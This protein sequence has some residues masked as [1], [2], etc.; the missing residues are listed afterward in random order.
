MLSIFDIMLI[1]KNL[2]TSRR[3]EICWIIPYVRIKLDKQNVKGNFHHA[4]IKRVDLEIS[5]NV[6]RICIFV[7]RIPLF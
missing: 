3:V 5:N 6:M 1:R 4:S 7:A 2:K